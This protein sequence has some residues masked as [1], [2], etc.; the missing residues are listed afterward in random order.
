MLKKLT[1]AALAALVASACVSPEVAP[2]A[3]SLD[4]VFVTK[5][6]CVTGT[7]RKGSVVAPSKVAT[8]T[9][10]GDAEITAAHVVRGC[11]DGPK[12]VMFEDIDFAIVNPG[13]INS[14]RAPY[15]GELV[16]FHGYPSTKRDNKTARSK[17]LLETQEG[18][19]TSIDRSSFF[20]F[21]N[22]GTLNLLTGHIWAW[23]D[24]VRGGYS[25]GAVMSVDTGDFLGILSTAS[26]EGKRAS[27]IPADIICEK[28]EEVL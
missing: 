17:V 9:K 19:V 2:Q 13:K 12:A 1:L 18:F 10:V 6:T 8:M 26:V 7:P 16:K 28:M 23:S 4:D 3:T 25:G 20:A 22:D 21:S 11:L 27:F 15:E 5:F 24:T 14:C